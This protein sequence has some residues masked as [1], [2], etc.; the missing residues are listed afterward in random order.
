MANYTGIQGQN[1]LIVDT[2]PANPTEGQIWYN[3]TT[4][5]L[6]G[7][8]YVEAWASG[9]NLTTARAGLGG[10]GATQSSFLAFGGGNPGTLTASESYNGTSWT[11][12]PSLNTARKALAGTGTLTAALGMGGYLQPGG[13]SAVESFNG[14]S[15]T[16]TTSL[17]TSR[18]NNGGAGTQTAAITF[19]GDLFP[20]AV[21]FTNTS[22]TFDGSTWTSTPNMNKTIT[23]S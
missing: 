22:L 12:T 10:A 4:N 6:K 13:S 21:R 1:I 23:T 5:L 18:F 2:D 14:S 16:S 15:W 20:G 17:P 3:S 19:G 11:N 8:K 7:L 9:G